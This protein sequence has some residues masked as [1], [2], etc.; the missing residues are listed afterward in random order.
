MIPTLSTAKAN[1]DKESVK[2]QIENA[3]SFSIT[4]SALFVPTFFEL[5]EAIGLFVYNSAESGRFLSF[6]AWLLIPIAVE[7][8]TSSMMNSLDLEIKSLI[9]Y[10]IG[11]AV[12]FAILFLFR[13]NFNVNILSIA[14]GVN[15]TLSSVLDIIDIKRKTQIKLS[16]IPALVKSVCLIFPAILLNRW[17]YALCFALPAFFR[18]AVAGGVS[19]VFMIGLNLI[20]ATFDLSMFVRKKEKVSKKKAKTVAKTRRA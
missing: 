13:N 8:I 3:I 11:S 9:N 15:L 12:L 6:S 16:F 19:L 7:S 17:L 2:R 20:F 18:I 10:L 14:M 5:G 4:L 1:G